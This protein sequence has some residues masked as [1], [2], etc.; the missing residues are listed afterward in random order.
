MQIRQCPV[1]ASEAANVG[2][3]VNSPVVAEVS[4]IEVS[5][6]IIYI[7]G[8][9]IECRV[10]SASLRRVFQFF[11]RVKSAG[12]ICVEVAFL[13]PR[14]LGERPEICERNVKNIYKDTLPL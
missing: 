12:K 10:Y 5:L 14:Y 6:R 1:N 2:E 3:Y 8:A 13:S 4:R 7:C 9:R 11:F